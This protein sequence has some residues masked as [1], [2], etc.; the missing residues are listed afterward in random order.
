ML[1]SLLLRIAAV[2]VIGVAVFIVTAIISI[3]PVIVDVVVVVAD[4]I[5]VVDA[6]ASFLYC[7]KSIM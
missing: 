7:R 4:D 6:L 1:S 2:F 5:V 3:A